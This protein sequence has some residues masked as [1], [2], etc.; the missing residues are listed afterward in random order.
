VTRG[1]EVTALQ[2]KWLLIA[3]KRGL[4]DVPFTLRFA[5]GGQ[6]VAQV[7]LRGYGAPNGMLLDSDD[8]LFSGRHARIL[9]LGYG[10]SCLSQP[11]EDQIGSEEGLTDMLEDWGRL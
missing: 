2:R 3:K 7:R 11:A 8:R 1:D 5:D 9:A 10:Y 6:I 4:V